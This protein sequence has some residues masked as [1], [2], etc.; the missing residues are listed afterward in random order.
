MDEKSVSKQLVGQIAYNNDL[1]ALVSKLE[2]QALQHSAEL[3]S[4]EAQNR[5]SNKE[6]TNELIECK[7][8]LNIAQQIAESLSS[9]A[10]TYL[11]E[12]AATHR[13][14]EVQGFRE[15]SMLWRK[16]TRYNL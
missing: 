1:L 15:R 11:S 8:K 2:E 3:E 13:F 5:A 6:L 4:V 12:K 9:K 7:R 10:R 14:M 16:L